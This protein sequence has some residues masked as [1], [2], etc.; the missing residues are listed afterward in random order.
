[1]KFNRMKFNRMKFNRM[2]LNRM[3]FNRMKLNRM[4]FQ[5]D[6]FQPDEFQPDEVCRMKLQPV[7]IQLGVSKYT[8]CLKRFW[9]RSK[10]RIVE[11]KNNDGRLN[12]F[13][14]L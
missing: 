4:K 6:E 12:M 5:P 7:E 9:N 2:K 1:M 13:M 10:R 3:K 11:G 14:C 8:V